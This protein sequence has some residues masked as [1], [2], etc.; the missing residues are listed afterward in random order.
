LFPVHFSLFPL[1]TT[2]SRQHTFLRHFEQHMP[3]LT[4]I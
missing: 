2:K 4:Y 1:V 3:I